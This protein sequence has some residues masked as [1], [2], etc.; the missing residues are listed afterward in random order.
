MS[1]SLVAHGLVL[2]LPDGVG[3]GDVAVVR[4]RHC[5]I[6]VVCF[7][8]ILCLCDVM[9]FVLGDGDVV[10]L[11]LRLSDI[12]RLLHGFVDLLGHGDVVRNLW[13]LQRDAD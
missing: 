9:R 10:L 5:D 8:F 6:H 11:H 13:R 7:G 1:V 3:N 12:V 4:L 2:G